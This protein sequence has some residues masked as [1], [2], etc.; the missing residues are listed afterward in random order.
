MMAESVEG[1]GWA[2]T[3]K[4]VSKSAGGK[5][6]TGKARDAPASE[7]GAEGPTA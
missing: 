2:F 3:E 5:M 6:A 4:G 7:T 1:S